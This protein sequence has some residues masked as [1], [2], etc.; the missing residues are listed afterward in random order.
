[1]LFN[2]NKSAKREQDILASQQDARDEKFKYK[3]PNMYVF[4]IDFIY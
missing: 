1:M 4:K 3:S 2:P